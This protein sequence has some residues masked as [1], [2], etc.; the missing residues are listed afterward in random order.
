MKMDRHAVGTVLF[1]F[2]KSYM[3]IRK[4]EV[5]DVMYIM[6]DAKIRQILK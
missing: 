6:Q 4:N 5:V 3:P 2:A 1:F